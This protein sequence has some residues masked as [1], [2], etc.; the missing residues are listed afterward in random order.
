M[1]NKMPF[2]VTHDDH[3]KDELLKNG[4]T[5]VEDQNGRYVFLNNRTIS[6]DQ[7]GK[8][9]FTDRLCM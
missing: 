2:V 5:L 1:N 6:F 8:V 4:F 9:Q 7:T 3:V